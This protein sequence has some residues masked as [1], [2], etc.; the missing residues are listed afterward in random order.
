MIFDISVLLFT[1]CPVSEMSYTPYLNQNYEE[2]KANSLKYGS[3]FE[4][5][6]FPACNGSLYRFKSFGKRIFWMRPYE[7]TDNPQFMIDGINPNDFAMGRL[8]NE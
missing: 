8:N 3:L 6:E 4:D 2:I 1:F 7:I 5:D